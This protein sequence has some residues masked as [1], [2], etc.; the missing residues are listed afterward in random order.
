M[1]DPIHSTK[2]SSKRPDLSK[3]NSR[4]STKEP[5][6]EL[7]A[8]IATG[9]IKEVDLDLVDRDEN[10]PR[11]FEEVLQD[12]EQFADELERDNF[13]LVQHPIYSIEPNGR[14]KVVVGERR[15]EAFR[16]KKR[17]KITAVCK[18]FTKEEREKIY[19][20]QYVENDGDLKKPLSP[21]SDA[22]WWRNY[23]DTFHRGNM[24][25]A[26]EAR[27]KASNDVSNR[28][29]LLEAPQYIQAAVAKHNISDPATYAALIRLDKRAG[30]QIV[31]GIL[32]DSEKD[33]LGTSLRT[34]VES[35]ARNAKV[36]ENRT[37]I[38]I[39]QSEFTGVSV[40][41]DAAGGA[42]GE[43]SSMV[44]FNNASH[45]LKSSAK[46]N[47]K[48]VPVKEVISALEDDLV[49]V[50][51]SLTKARFSVRLLE[52]TKGQGSAKAELASE[53][54]KAREALKLLYESLMLSDER[55]D[56]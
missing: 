4:R 24:S 36:L 28:L 22:K 40:S 51:K 55:N 53:I 25:A 23:I 43:N 42:E 33:K 41:Q 50:I 19:V 30:S 21:I 39:E 54:E 11:P 27:G 29:A 26:A 9:E 44:P 1:S 8:L 38:A 7:Q 6:A 13:V 3:F 2:S 45:D 20:M 34:Y 31:E 15:T 16:L 18:Y 46:Q 32:A 10:Q 56:G 14:F 35:V 52:S 48:K 12:L 37:P 49:G 17:E 47:V 5:N